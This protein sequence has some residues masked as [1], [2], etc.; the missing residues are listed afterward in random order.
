MGLESSVLLLPLWDISAVA[1]PQVLALA[2]EETPQ[3]SNIFTQ[4]YLPF[5]NSVAG[6]QVFALAVEETRAK[7]AKEE[8]GQLSGLHIYFM[9]LSQRSTTSTTSR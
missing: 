8:D 2:V 3:C 5:R 9:K 6:P 7:E 1:G 4:I